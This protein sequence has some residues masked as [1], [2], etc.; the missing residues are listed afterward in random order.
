MKPAA[1]DFIEFLNTQVATQLDPKGMTYFAYD[2]FIP[3]NVQIKLRERE[4]ALAKQPYMTVN[5]VRATVG[6]PPVSGGDTVLSNPMLVPVGNEAAPTE[7]PEGSED[8]P[9]KALPR[10]VRQHIARGSSINGIVDGIAE[11]VVSSRDPDAESHR[12]FV[13]RVESHEELIAGKVRDF[14]NRQ[15]REVIQRLKRITKNVNRS[16]VFDMPAEVAVLV[17]FVSPM[18]GILLTEQV[19]AEFEAQGF[20]GLPDTSDERLKRI[21]ELAATRLSKSYNRT[22]ADLIMQTLNEGIK[23]GDDI[24]QLTDRVQAVYA[25][26]DAYRAVQVAKTEAFYIANEGSREAYRQSGVVETLRWY[27]AEDERMCEFCDPMNGTEVG[28]SEVFFGKGETVTGR[29][30]GVMSTDYRAI[31][32]PPLHPNCRCFIRPERISVD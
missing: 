18:L 12:K 9:Q 8:E 10:H 5:E 16:D 1:D 4:V 29:D 17:D 11:A 32:V 2:E 24:T 20:D 26:S 30:G 28:V 7:P 14:N 19:I 6:L 27:T 22:T 13:G 21:V 23:A 31:D 25:F 15:L 3:E